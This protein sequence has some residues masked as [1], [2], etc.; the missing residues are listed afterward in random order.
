MPKLIKI[1]ANSVIFVL[2]AAA[3][4][5]TDFWD[6]NLVPGL[7]APLGATVFLLYLLVLL[8]L[9]GADDPADGEG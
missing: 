2:G 7:W 3:L 4:V 6:W 9:G 1:A 5:H 8:A